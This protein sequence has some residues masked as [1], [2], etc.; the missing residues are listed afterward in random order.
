MYGTLDEKGVNQTDPQEKQRGEGR[1]L[2]RENKA[3]KR[4]NNKG[5]ISSHCHLNQGPNGE[6]KCH[7]NVHSS[8][9]ESCTSFD[10]QHDEEDHISQADLSAR[11]RLIVAS[12]ICLVFMI[13]EIVGGVMSNSLAIATDAAHLLSDFASFMISL[14]A[15]W[16]S[17][18]PATKRMNFGWHRA[19]VLGALISV[20]MIWLVTAFLV[21]LAIE[22]IRLEHFE[23]DT[24][25]MV[26]TATFGLLANIVMGVALHPVADGLSHFGHQ[27]G[28]GHGHS[29]H[30]H[31]DHVKEEPDNSDQL[32]IAK[33]QPHGLLVA[34]SLSSK[35]KPPRDSHVS[36]QMLQF[37]QTGQPKVDQ[38]GDNS[39][40]NCSKSNKQ[41][42]AAASGPDGRRSQENLNV[43]AAFIHV[44]GDFLQS[45]GVLIAA[46][47]IHINPSYAIID[48]ICTFLFSVIVMFTTVTITRDA[49]NILMEGIPNDVSFLDIRKKL[50]SLPS[51]VRVHNLRIW[52]ITVDKIALSVH[53]VIDGKQSSCSEALEMATKALK[54]VHDFSEITIQVEELRDDMRSCRVCQRDDHQVQGDCKKAPNEVRTVSSTK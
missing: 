13:A 35:E 5:R 1:D 47:V 23:L 18:R 30:C 54:D 14:F 51:V 42:S 21:Y 27:H 2:Q 45:L 46:L 22:R 4:R 11:R 17:T 6:H 44:I 37:D 20:F 48:P 19:E 28:G 36:I 34:S 52:S 12:L 8:Q 10:D 15:L 41:L 43:R 50:C 49:I 29:G 40:D 3:L 9:E 38:K 53:L 16:L 39:P 25:I 31:K 32:P 7:K 33:H 24:R 26:A